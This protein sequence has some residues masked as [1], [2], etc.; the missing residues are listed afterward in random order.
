MEISEWNARSI[1]FQQKIEKILEIYISVL[2]SEIF[3]QAVHR[4]NRLLYLYRKS[5]I[6]N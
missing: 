6:L 2:A 4:P 1:L 3:L 5:K